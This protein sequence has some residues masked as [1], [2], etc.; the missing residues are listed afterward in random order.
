MYH[1]HP[2]A[3]L[4]VPLPPPLHP[5]E[6]RPCEAEDFAPLFPMALI[7]QEVSIERCPKK[8][9]NFLPAPFFVCLFVC[10]L[11]CCRLF[12]GRAA[13][14]VDFPADFS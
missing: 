2:E 14:V 12:F 9:L 5:G 1:F 4:P 7:A 3:D 11:F 8:T 6:L 13:E 10:L